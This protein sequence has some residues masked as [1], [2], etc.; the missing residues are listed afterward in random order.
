MFVKYSEIKV[1]A[2]EE[3][4]FI[5]ETLQQD[6]FLSFRRNKRFGQN[7][8]FCEKKKMSGQKLLKKKKRIL[9]NLFFVKQ[10]DKKNK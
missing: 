8:Y 7:P 6:L 5:H 3:R 10:S 9:R 1:L 4:F 2:G